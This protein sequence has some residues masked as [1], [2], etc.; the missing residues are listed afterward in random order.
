MAL[1]L[2]DV[3]REVRSDS[4]ATL[5][6]RAASASIAAAIWALD[7]LSKE[8]IKLWSRAVDSLT[9]EADPRLLESLAGL[10]SPIAQAR[11][12]GS[13]QIDR[14]HSLLLLETIVRAASTFK[15]SDCVW[16]CL[17]SADMAEQNREAGDL[18]W[19]KAVWKEHME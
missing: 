6:M 13:R 12:G 15:R 16:V 7:Y 5:A 3:E 2:Y 8:E 18:E 11:A 9:L 19:L 4:D 1:A 14:Y 17:R 10:R